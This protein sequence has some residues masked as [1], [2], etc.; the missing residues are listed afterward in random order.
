MKVIIQGLKEAKKYQTLLMIA[1]ISTLMLSL[2]NLVAPMVMSKMTSLVAAGLK[3]ADLKQ[4]V[5]FTFLL[6]SLYILRILFRFLSSYLAHKAAWNLVKELRIK[7]YSKLQGLSVD[8]FRNHQSGDL[9]SRTINDTAT[10]ELLYA[11]LLPESATNL[12]TIIGVSVILFSINPKLAALT[13]L[14]IPLILLMGV[15]FAKRVRPNFDETQKSLGVLTTQLINNFSGIQEIQIFNRQ[16]IAIEQVSDKAETFTKFMLRAL[17]LNAVFHPTVE[18]LTAI[19]SVIIVGFGGYL[20][21]LGQMAVGD[22]VAFMLYL[23]LFYTPIT[24]LADLLEQLQQSLAGATRVMEILNSPELISNSNE[25]F[26]LKKT[27]GEISFE[28][29]SF[30]YVE[31]V[32][33]LKD[34]SFKVKQGEMLALVGATGV[35][36]STIAQLTARFYDPQKGSIKIDERDI[37]E[38]EINSLLK[39]IAMVLQDTFLFD[40]TIAE[41]I[42]FAKADS[43]AKEIEKVAIIARIHNDIV[44]MPDGYNTKVGERG[45]K[46]SGGQKQRIAIARALLTNAPILI[47]DEATAAVDIQTESAIQK[48]I[49]A[50]ATDKTIIVI[51]H[52]ISTIRNAN[53]ILVLQNGKIIQRGT[54]KQ[55]MAKDGLYKNMCITQKKNNKDKTDSLSSKQ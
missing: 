34:V 36:K 51:A 29:V 13:C 48:S 39:N 9:I 12:I 38:I 46:L 23:V 1:A 22:I 41:N 44:A 15:F 25:A 4:I 16:K 35:G 5:N 55:L 37:K 17:K 3:E 45:A 20:A 28:N 42:A 24:G 47:L 11:H 53:C 26:V 32:S 54:H 40:G 27:K 2:I 7:V 31:D 43:S 33:V 18:F 50:I 14:P 21:Y 6:L 19:G 52:R 8:Y 10:F 30:S 49:R